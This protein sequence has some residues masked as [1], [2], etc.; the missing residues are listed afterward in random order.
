MGSR[1]RTRSGLA[2]SFIYL[3]LH[4]VIITLQIGFT[5]VFTPQKSRLV[6]E[7]SGVIVPN[8]LESDE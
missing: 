1:D 5:R 4:C 2:V 6:P 7:N 3:K 8:F